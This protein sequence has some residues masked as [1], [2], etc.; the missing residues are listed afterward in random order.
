MGTARALVAGSGTWLRFV[1]VSYVRGLHNG[2][3]IPSMELEGLEVLAQVS[4][5]DRGNYTGKR[6]T[7]RETRR[8][9]FG[10]GRKLERR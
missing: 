7:R 2:W 1:S 9:V 4:H 8:E 10:C 5:G 6:E 3:H